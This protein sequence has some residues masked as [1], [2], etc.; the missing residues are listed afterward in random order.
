MGHVMWALCQGVTNWQ[1]IHPATTTKPKWR[2]KG[3]EDA[4]QIELPL[5]LPPSSGYE[6]ILTALDVL[7]IYLF[8]QPKSSQDARTVARGVFNIITKHAHL[9]TTMNSDGGKA[10]ISQVMKETTEVW[11]VTLENAQTIE[12]IEGTHASL[13]KTLEIG[14]GEQRLM[15]HNNVKNAVSNYN[16]NFHATIGCEPSRVLNGS[17]LYNVLDLTM[18]VWPQKPPMPYSQTAQ[19][20]V[21]QTQMNL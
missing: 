9:P 5:E 2:Y 17:V 6:N 10:F 13:A 14:T 11:G 8:A 3:P 18:G 19:N 16:T 20:I 12:M 4:M 1:Q 15:W 7:S 21:E